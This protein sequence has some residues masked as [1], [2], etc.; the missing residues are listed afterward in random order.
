M[1]VTIKN[2]TVQRFH[3]T[4][5]EFPQFSDARLHDKSHSTVSLTRLECE[6]FQ[7]APESMPSF[8]GAYYQSI[9]KGTTDYLKL[10]GLFYD[11]SP[12]VNVR[13]QGALKITNPFEGFNEGGVASSN[14]MFM[15]G[16]RNTCSIDILLEIQALFR[17]SGLE[18]DDWSTALTQFFYTTEMKVYWTKKLDSW[19]RQHE[20][21]QWEERMPW[22]HAVHECLRLCTSGIEQYLQ[23]KWKAFLDMSAVPATRYNCPFEFLR[24]A[25]IFS[26]QLPTTVITSHELFSHL[27]W[28]LTTP[29]ATSTGRVYEA[30]LKPDQLTRILREK[31]GKDEVNYDSALTVLM[32]CASETKFHTS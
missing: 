9:A 27:C 23:S 17:A 13:G 20:H 22:L 8:P 31:L 11:Q 12:D 6:G 32:S 25:E 24:E 15:N 10:S 2:D 16:W 26:A 5:T 14:L 1:V 3:P 4:S 30:P 18:I 7:Q 28:S 19:Y 29:H 21:S